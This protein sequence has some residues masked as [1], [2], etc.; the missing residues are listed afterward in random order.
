MHLAAGMS[1]LSVRSSLSAS[2]CT[3]AAVIGWS[4]RR[5]T[6]ATALLAHSRACSRVSS[7]HRTF[8]FRAQTS[9]SSCHA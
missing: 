2:R 5:R 9:G 1:N 6:P 8:W 7:S 3:V 4:S